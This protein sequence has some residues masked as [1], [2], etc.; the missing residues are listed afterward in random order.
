MYSINRTHFR[1]LMVLLALAI[2]GWSATSLWGQ[3]I[4]GSIYGQVT[5][6]SG[7]AIA[8]ATVTV[9]DVA[10]GTSVQA[11]TN[12][13]GE[14]SVE[15]LIPDVYDV[16]VA[17]T[18][19]RGTESKG[20]RVSADTSPKV[21]LKLDVGLATETV[22]VTTEVPQLK[23]DRA[24]VALVLNEKTV[25]DLPNS[26]RNFASLELL[27]PGTQ[28]MG[29]SQNTA[30]NPQGSPTVQINGQHFS[31]VAYELDGAANQDPILGQIV[32]NPPLDAVTE[33]K[34]TT[35]NY[36]AQFGQAVAAVVTAQ[37]K[38]GTNGFHGDLFDYRR[39]DATQARNP[40][41]QFA[42]DPV[43]RRLL[44]PAKY[45][46]F[47]ASIGGPIRKNKAFFFADYQGT[48]QILGSS[49]IV[50]VPTALARSS[51]LSGNGCDL[52]DYLTANGPAKGQIY[53]P[54]VI[55]G[56]GPAPFVND[57]IPT[58]FLSPQAL[59]LLALIPA[60]NAAGTTNN[61]SGSGS[62]SLH[63]DSVD[64]KIDDQL[65]ERTH[66]FGR[67]SY[68]GNGTSSSTIFG[69]GGGQGFSS[70]TNSFGGTASGRSQSAV[71]G[72]DIALSPKLLTDFRLGYLRYHVKTQKYDGEENLATGVGIPGLNLGDSFTAGAPAFFIENASGN[73]G[74]GLSNF[75]SALGVN[76]CN[77]PLLETEDQYQIVNNWTKIMGT[78]SLKFGV[79]VR[80]ARNL[81][82]PSDSNRAGELHFSA[83][84][85]E[86]TTDPTLTSPGGMGLAT[87]L[88]GDVTNM[89]R[90]V[91]VSTNAKESQKRMFTYL[92]DSWRITPKLT[93]NY[94]LRWELYFPETVNGKG[95][96]GFPDL[97]TGEIRVAG[98]G[99]FNTAMN[100]SKTWKTLAPR[101]GVA[102]Q[103]NPKTVIRTGYGRSFDIGVFGS[104]FG[105][106]LTQNLPVLVNQN[107][108]NSGANTAA[109]N[110]AVGPTAFVFPAIPSSGSIPIGVGNNAKIRS[111]PNVFP[112]IDAWNFAV[113]RQLTNTSSVTVAYVGNKGT[114]TFMGD[115][116]STNPNEA[117]PC[118]PA[119]Q[120][121]TG[122]A[123]CYNPAAPAGSLT[124]TS[125]TSQLRPYFSRF[126]FTQDLTFY[127]NGFD[128]NYN[129]LQVS[130]EKR[131][132]QGLQLNANFAFQRGYNYGS[133]EE[134][135]KKVLWGRLD[136]LREK[137]L[138]LFGN[139]EL[140][141]G[142]SRRFGGDVPTWLNY[143]IGG[144]EL[145]TSVD[146]AS[147][148]PFTANLSNC[149]PFTPAGPC[150]PD[151]GSGSFPLN[152]TAFDPTT[153]SRTYFVPPG[154][155]GAFTS[156]SLDQTGTSPRN[157]FT[158]P[159]LLN[160]DL[161]LM[162][163]FPIRETVAVEFRMDA[164][165]VFNIINPRNPENTCID[166]TAASGA[167]SIHGMAL[168]TA[169]RQ[170]D[171]ALT[172]KF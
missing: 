86:N 49:A 160:A 109:F 26:G 37:T 100:V 13:V 12:S 77:C 7:A 108:T 155:G 57:F 127:H 65:S 170:L 105:H 85:T 31:G 27:I 169:P 95:Q 83:T 93:V 156:P 143:V 32:I 17:A 9:K 21:D 162:K 134:V 41:N 136:D 132:S 1:W 20:I 2:A 120:S 88:I 19:F 82:V 46:Q 87:F 150:R 33:A 168:G 121:I 122:Q 114:H 72:M 79:D 90:Y 165:N 133:D 153:H 111:D 30:E 142:R 147:G 129:A 137:Q 67:Y 36:D 16:A 66:A 167:G 144:Y 166:C 44:P 81:R 45:N 73:A 125:D 96:G 146:W 106:M 164:F 56:A 22:T 99:P 4:Y 130:F 89:S 128:T 94:G 131:F 15:H 157:A 5:D 47:G 158:G 148:L 152:L 172:V 11:T 42:P 123:L 117:A 118:L 35:Q 60:P 101:V 140:P 48:R 55:T 76:A 163:T 104:I 171:F 59:A 78:H 63:N 70:P 74:D 69:K 18:G 6:S 39:T 64:V 38:S 53:N 23:T 116:K 61:Y 107:L 110:L 50:T 54:R 113:Q 154:L 80:Y 34:I 28:V 8:S 43:T 40:Y 91:S 29:W 62:G 161:S 149:S 52:S 10:K 138:T 24:D 14:Y 51:C 126:G 84:D 124:E 75:G 115:D 92:Q 112:T 71:L 119:S 159:G 25:S 68:F 97:N 58:Q 103:L 102:Y 145:S 141:F 151:K 135:Y 98:Y 3:A 139:Y